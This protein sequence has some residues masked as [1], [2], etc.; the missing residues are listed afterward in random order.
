MWLSKCLWP[1]RFHVTNGDYFIAEG[2]LVSSEV[3]DFGSLVTDCGN[4]S[5][6]LRY[7]TAYLSIKNI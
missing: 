3:V 2:L 6:C 5:K 1:F 7:E 4:V